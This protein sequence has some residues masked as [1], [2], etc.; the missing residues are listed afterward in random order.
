MVAA[1]VDVLKPG[2]DSRTQRG[3]STPFKGPKPKSVNSFA[4]ERSRGS[5]IAPW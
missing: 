5:P 3:P 1:V 2:L 4:V